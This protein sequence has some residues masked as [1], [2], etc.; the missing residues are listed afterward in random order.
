MRESYLACFPGGT[1][2]RLIL[3][4]LW[5]TVTG[6]DYRI[7][8]DEFNSTHQES[9]WWSPYFDFPTSGPDSMYSSRLFPALKLNEEVDGPY[10][11]AFCHVFPNFDTLRIKAPDARLVLVSYHHSDITEI[12]TNRIRKNSVLPYAGKLIKDLLA[13]PIFRENHYADL[14]QYYKVL[15]ERL[16]EDFFNLAIEKGIRDIV[17]CFDVD[18]FNEAN[19]TLDTIPEDFRNKTL[20]IKYSDIFNY[21]AIEKIENFLQKKIGPHTRQS[22]EIYVA[23]RITIPKEWYAG[24]LSAIR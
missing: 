19:L 11:M 5:R 14:I 4:V 7:K 23:N 3:H 24:I 22:Y 17:R 12:V 1:S 16:T 10:N 18:P 13:D 2:G 9:P 15:P 6:Q 20:I 8:F 21:T